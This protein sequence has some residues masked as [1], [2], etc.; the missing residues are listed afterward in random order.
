MSASNPG[1]F[2]YTKLEHA[3]VFVLLCG[4]AVF[5]TRTVRLFQQRGVT[6]PGEDETAGSDGR[7]EGEPEDDDVDHPGALHSD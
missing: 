4:M 1:D 5:L 6:I 2:Q 3:L 7:G